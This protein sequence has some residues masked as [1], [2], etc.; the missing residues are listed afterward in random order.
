MG[1]ALDARE[2]IATRLSPLILDHREVDI[3]ELLQWAIGQSGYLPWRGVAER[4]L[5]YDHGYTVL[6]SAAPPVLSRGIALRCT[7]N[8]DANA[9][10]D[11]IRALAPGVAAVVIACARRRIRPACFVGVTPQKINKTIKTVSRTKKGWRRRRGRVTSTVTGW[12]V[13][14]AT[15]ALARQAY[16]AWHHA[17][18]RMAQ[19]LAGRLETYAIAGFS[20]PE[21]PW[22]TIG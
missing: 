9:V 15:V 4:E 10:I 14:P 7:V 22:D 20:A 2:I 6:F 1:G 5:Q 12:D 18:G 8:G 21:R 11:E 3:E 17:L 16:T 13:E 19:R